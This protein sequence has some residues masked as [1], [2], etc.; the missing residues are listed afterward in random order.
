MKDRNKYYRDVKKL[1]PVNGKKETD[2]LKNIKEQ[3]DEYDDYTYEQLEQTFGTP[4]EVVTSYYQTINS[5]YLLKRINL[6]R[7]V[8]IAISIMIVLS[9]TLW[10]FEMY[11]LNQLYE[12]VK[13]QIH[14]H[15][16]EIIEDFGEV[17]D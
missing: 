11:R 1:F 14:G 5:A 4:I 15:Y 8:N 9:I 7:I 6:K 13:T 10:G 17:R 16:E 12:E 3:I 2:Y